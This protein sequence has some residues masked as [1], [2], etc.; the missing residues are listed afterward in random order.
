M[1]I[2]ETSFRKKIKP[3][4]RIFLV[5]FLYFSILSFTIAQIH[6]D[7]K[8]S[9]IV[10]DKTIPECLWIF[11]QENNIPFTFSNN[12]FDD[13]KYSFN[14]I[15]QKLSR[16]LDKLITATG[17]K[18]TIN[19]GEVLIFRNASSYIT[20]NGY[21]YDQT[22]GEHLIG[23]NVTVN[24]KGNKKIGT[25]SNVYGFFSLKT[26]IESESIKISYLG[27]R[28]VTISLSAIKNTP[29]QITLQPDFTID[30]I[31]ITTQ[32][33]DKSSNYNIEQFKNKELNFFKQLPSLGGDVDIIRSIQLLPGSQNGPDGYGGLHVRGG[34]ADQNLVLLDGVPIYN[35]YHALGL[36]SIFD[37]SVIKNTKYLRG[38]FPARYGGRLSSVLDV[39]TKDGNSK[40]WKFNVGTGLILSK[41]LA[42]GPIIKD[43][44]SFMFGARRTHLDPFLENYSKN[45]LSTEDTN[46]N[47]NYF[48]GEIISKLNFKISPQNKMYI[49]YYKGRDSYFREDN[50]V[51][52]FTDLT[53]ESF[54][55]QNLDWGNELVSLRWNNQFN[56]NTFANLTMT[57]S[58]F[59]FTSID[60][61]T[62]KRINQSTVES[63]FT[64]NSSYL[65]RI[66]NISA[67]YDIDYVP[68][69]YH[70]V[71]FGVSVNN[72]IF[73]PG[74][75]SSKN[76]YSES[77]T[78]LIDTLF[79]APLISNYNINAF[80]EDS[81]EISHEFKLNAGIFNVLYLLDSKTIFHVDPRLSL[82]WLPHSKWAIRLSANSMTQ[83]LHLLTRAGSS[84]PNDLW[85]P[86]TSKV[87]P[88][89]AWMIDLGLDY[90]INK[91]FQFTI[92]AYQKKLSNII[93]Y[94][95][96]GFRQ[97]GVTVNSIN[98]ED[99][100]TVGQGTSKGIELMLKYDHP[101]T[102]A[103][104]N[105]TYSSAKRQFDDINDGQEFPF[106]FNLN[107]VINF[108]FS[109][110]LSDHW[111]MATNWTYSSGM[112]TNL[113]LREWQYINQSG[114]YDFLYKDLGT[115]NSYQ[116]PANHRLDIS[117]HYKNEVKWGE[118]LLKIGVYN[119]YNHKNI[120]QVKPKF[121]NELFSNK[122]KAVSLVPF[123]PYF[124][125]AFQF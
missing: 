101:K 97:T 113:A 54:E 11:S 32:E 49:S 103:W 30:E 105:Y 78:E 37:D 16:I 21:I 75:A 55:K 34:N 116:L 26:P 82:T 28:P 3:I 17:N 22:T 91:H 92:A 44:M 87:S 81:W 120:I 35:P 98:W 7:Q 48:F 2:K 121:D 112:F 114:Q 52:G 64:N 19:E 14:I 89:R 104:I 72:D 23:A 31:V 90:S 42:Q 1:I 5:G 40:K 80:V 18:Y 63:T 125:I 124:S 24:S 41:V 123:L 93:S 38:H 62:E 45:K 36:Y 76:D 6:S 99:N 69:P 43:K 79:S 15:D 117:A 107:H 56:N 65:S 46:G 100:I 109:H 60:N 108:V 39:R 85:V 47:F 13:T 53:F 29:L 27:Y 74:L 51:Y 73:K 68:N 58:R 84:L 59:Q 88:Q 33:K 70:Y 61:Y 71:R 115:K 50:E 10:N 122:F 106:Q 86:S 83:Y 8:Y 66:E 102:S 12:D 4:N 111:S 9:L 95:D 119:T 94:A 110:K 25:S 96:G 67:K 118:Y 77:E 57:Y 20:I